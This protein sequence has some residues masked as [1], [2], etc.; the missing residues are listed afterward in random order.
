MGGKHTI[1]IEGGGEQSLSTEGGVGGR[2][3]SLR[4]G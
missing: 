3:L 4:E 1:S 2:V